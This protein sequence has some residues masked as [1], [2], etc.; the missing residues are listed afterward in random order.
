MQQMFPDCTSPLIVHRLDMSTSGIMLIA[1]TKDAHQFL[2]AQFIKRKVKK[3][4][5]ALLEGKLELLKGKISLPLRL[6]LEDRP[7][8]MV[9]NQFGKN[10]ETEYEVISIVDG[11]TKIRFFPLTG[12]THQLRVHAAHVLGLNAPI[13]GDDLYGKV[14]KRLYL[15]AE[16]ITFMHPK[17]KEWMKLE[18]PSSF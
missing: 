16:K 1:K 17:T 11:R 15:H 2:Q 9:C 10:A 13:V 12:R 18:V 7:R 3:E 8:Q 5:I 6:D 4:Y 14:D